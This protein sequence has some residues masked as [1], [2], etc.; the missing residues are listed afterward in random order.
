MSLTFSVDGG[1]TFETWKDLHFAEFFFIQYMYSSP[2]FILLDCTRNMRYV[3]VMH[4]K[5]YPES[6]TIVARV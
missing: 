6:S 3:I 1:Y 2:A 4:L 5:E